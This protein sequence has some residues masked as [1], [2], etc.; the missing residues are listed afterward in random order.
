MAKT[1]KV[2]PPP[3][4]AHTPTPL[5]REALRQLIKTRAK[6]AVLKK[7][8]AMLQKIIMAG[9]GG[10]AFGYRAYI[11]HIRA[12]TYVRTVKAHDALRVVAYSGPS[13][14]DCL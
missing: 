1:K 9:G 3:A 12:S 5:V 6:Q 2:R 14:G 13:K 7:R 10:A 4:G 8:A 11:S